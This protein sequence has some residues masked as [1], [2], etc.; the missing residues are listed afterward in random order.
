MTGVATTIGCAIAISVTKGNLAMGRVADCMAVT[1]SVTLFTVVVAS[2]DRTVGGRAA[3]QGWRG[4]VAVGAGILMNRNHCLWIVDRIIFMTDDT[5]G[6]LQEDGVWI[7]VTTMLWHIIIAMTSDTGSDCGA[8]PFAVGN[9][10]IDCCLQWQALG[11]RHGGGIIV[12]TEV[13][14]I[15]ITVM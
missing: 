11:I 15:A 4:A 7:T 10:I 13:T 1:G 14:T 12:M 9:G 8:S 3:L 6:R 2:N 5:V